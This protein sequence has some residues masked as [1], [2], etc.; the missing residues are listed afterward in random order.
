[1][2]TDWVEALMAQAIAEDDPKI[3]AALKTI[4]SRNK[5]KA[6]KRKI[7]RAK[8]IGVVD[9]AISDAVNRKAPASKKVIKA[10]ER[11]LD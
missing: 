11:L 3:K 6:E 1:M 9:Q 5:D 4:K 7:T 2:A 10:Y 8:T